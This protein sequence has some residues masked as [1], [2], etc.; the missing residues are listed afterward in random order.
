M[1]RN[2]ELMKNY[3]LSSVMAVFTGAAPLG[4]ETAKELQGIFPSWA[5]RQGYGMMH[6]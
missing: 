5:I 2:K 3:D 1:L 4:A 6:S